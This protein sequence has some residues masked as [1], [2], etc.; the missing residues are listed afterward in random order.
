MK[1]VFD[2]SIQSPSEELFEQCT[3]DQLVKIAQLFG[4]GI[5]DKVENVKIA[6]KNKLL[7]AEIW[8]IKEVNKKSV[9][10]PVVTSVALTIE[11]QRELLVLQGENWKTQTLRTVHTEAR[12]TERLQRHWAANLVALS[13]FKFLFDLIKDVFLWLLWWEPRGMVNCHKVIKQKTELAEVE[14]QP[15][16]QHLIK[17]EN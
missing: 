2:D 11:Q 13:L 16:R 9:S 3:Q 6:L 10:S 12:R 1:Y 17:K 15:Y 14:L 8:V 7:E 4:I 5:T